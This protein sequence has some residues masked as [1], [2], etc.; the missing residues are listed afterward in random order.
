MIYS[1]DKNIKLKGV[2]GLQT[3]LSTNGNYSF[4]GTAKQGDTKG[5]FL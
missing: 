3:S 1:L 5:L 2:D 4:V